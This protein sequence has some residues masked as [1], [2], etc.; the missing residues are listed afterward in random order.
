MRNLWHAEPE[1]HRRIE[2]KCGQVTGG[3]GSWPDERAGDVRAAL[4]LVGGACA[5]VQRVVS[6][7][8]KQ[9]SRGCRETTR[10]GN[11]VTGAAVTM[12]RRLCIH[13]YM[14]VNLL[15]LENCRHV[16]L[17]CAWVQFVVQASVVNSHG[18]SGE[19]S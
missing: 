18:A 16:E 17:E 9:A 7:G 14:F 3:G 10:E 2:L 6:G 12:M 13:T 1:N 8:N 11:A 4:T 19:K 5:T 15:C